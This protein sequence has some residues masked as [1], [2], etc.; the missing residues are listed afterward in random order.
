MKAFYL[1]CFFSL[2]VQG[3]CGDQVAL[4]QPA[5]GIM[6]DSISSIG[7]CSFHN[8]G[9]VIGC[10]GRAHCPLPSPELLQGLKPR[11]EMQLIRLEASA[12]VG[13]RRRS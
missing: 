9:K 7:H 4:K 8:S 2:R 6:G 5:L 1:A 10:Y 13:V 12:L 3:W 11:L